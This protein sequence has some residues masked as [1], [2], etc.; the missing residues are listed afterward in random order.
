V[1]KRFENGI[2]QLNAGEYVDSKSIL[3]RLYLDTA[4]NTLYLIKRH[5]KFIRTFPTWFRNV[6]LLLSLYLTECTSPVLIHN[7]M[8]FP[9]PVIP[10]WLRDTLSMVYMFIYVSPPRLRSTIL[11]MP[12][13]LYVIPYWLRDNLLFI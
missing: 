4:V 8:Y 6:N 7:H 10:P 5:F 12:L 3:K 9:L 13:S 11:F 2:R 1:S